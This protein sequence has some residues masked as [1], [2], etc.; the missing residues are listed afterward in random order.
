MATYT[1]PSAQMTRVSGR[2]VDE[3]Q[4]LI[5][6]VEEMLATLDELGDANTD[7]LR[8]KLNKRVSLARDS[9]VHAVDGSSIRTRRVLRPA[10]M[11]VSIASLTGFVI[12]LVVASG[13]KIEV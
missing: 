1:E 3:V 4:E 6:R 7:R 5:G 10:L 12:G 13:K 8:R 11:A 2:S 9:L